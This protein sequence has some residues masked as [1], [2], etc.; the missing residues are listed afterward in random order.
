MMELR[1]LSVDDRKQVA[2]QALA[3]LE[4]ALLQSTIRLMQA[5][6][7][8]AAHRKALADAEALLA[9]PPAPPEV[10]A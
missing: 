7:D 2:G 9:L 4:L 8:H 10:I 3:Q 1:F 6:A 5:K